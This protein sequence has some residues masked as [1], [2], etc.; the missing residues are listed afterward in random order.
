MGW[1]GGGLKGAFGKGVSVEGGLYGGGRRGR[2]DLGVHGGVSDVVE[3]ETGP[4]RSFIRVVEDG[5][6]V[7]GGYA[8]LEDQGSVGLGDAAAVVE[9]GK[10]SVAAVFQG[11]GDEDVTG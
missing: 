6:Q 3:R 4:V 7:A 8:G 10:G 11:G 1:A 9:D 2:E 5:A